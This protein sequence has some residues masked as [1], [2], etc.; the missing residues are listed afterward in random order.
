MT[1]VLGLNRSGFDSQRGTSGGLGTL[2]RNPW[3][4]QIRAPRPGMGAGSGPWPGAGHT[5]GA[6]AMG[7]AQAKDPHSGHRVGAGGTG[8][9]IGAGHDIHAW[10]QDRRRHLAQPWDL[11]RPSSRRSPSNRRSPRSLV[12]LH[13]PLR[14]ATTARIGAGNSCRTMPS[15]RPTSIWAHSSASP[16]TR[17]GKP[18]C[19]RAKTVGG[20]RRRRREEETGDDEILGLGRQAVSRRVGIPRAPYNGTP[21]YTQAR[22]QPG[23]SDKGQSRRRNGMQSAALGHERTRTTSQTASASSRA[24]AHK[25]I[26]ALVVDVPRDGQVRHE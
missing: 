14:N 1:S 20:T 6:Q 26:E 3:F 4:E 16:T 22:A 8:H 13:R 5:V 24:V 11:R 18:G 7:L 19:V 17:C 15:L 10:P 9:G 25:V 21:I 12:S 2:P 23:G